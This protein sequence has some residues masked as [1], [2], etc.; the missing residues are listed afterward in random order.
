VV[1]ESVISC[2]GGVVCK[3]EHE[4]DAINEMNN[5]PVISF[6]IDCLLMAAG[7]NSESDPLEQKSSDMEIIDDF[8]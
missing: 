2:A 6:F 3:L 7:F 4:I 5:R 1:G 8:G